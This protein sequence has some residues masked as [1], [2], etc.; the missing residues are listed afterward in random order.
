MPIA[1]VP[2]NRITFASQVVKTVMS[3]FTFNH[4]AD[5]FTQS[6]VLMRRIIEA[7]RPSREQRY[8]RVMTS[9]SC[10]LVGTH[11]YLEFDTSG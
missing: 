3:M 10:C 5:A 4:L 1:K 11:Q 2:L 8:T 9:L 7:V 6:D